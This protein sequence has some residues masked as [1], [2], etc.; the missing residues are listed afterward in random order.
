[1][2]LGFILVRLWPRGSPSPSVDRSI[3]HLVRL[4]RFRGMLNRSSDQELSCSFLFSPLLFS[5]FQFD[6][7]CIIGSYLFCSSRLFFSL[8][9]FF[10]PSL[11]LFVFR[12]SLSFSSTFLLLLVFLSLIFF[13]FPLPLSLSLFLS[14][15]F[16]PSSRPAFVI[17]CG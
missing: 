16:S 11:L 9:S 3:C 10:S 17:I 1:M 15:I 7:S 5:S 12:L 8:L 4:E 13:S 2:C 14:Q 6:L